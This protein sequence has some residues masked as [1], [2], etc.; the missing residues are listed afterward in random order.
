[1]KALFDHTPACHGDPK[2]FRIGELSDH[3]YFIPHTSRESA[4][5]KR[6]GS[7]YFQ[8]LCGDD[9]LFCYKPSLYDLEDFTQDDADTSEF[10]PITVPEVW[11]THGADRAQ[12]MT[13]PYPF[14]FDPPH[15]PEADPCGAY[16]KEFDGHIT[17]GKRYELC[18]E[19][20]D[21]CV[22]V[23]LN[24]SFVGYGETP[25]HTSSFDVTPYLHEGRNRLCAVVLKWCS[26]SY[27][28]D[29]DKLRLSGLFRDVYLL[30]RSEDGLRD[31][32]ITADMRGNVTLTAKASA[33]VTAEIYD[34]ET[35][36][37]HGAIETDGPTAVRVSQPTLWSAE[38]PYL[39]ELVLTCAGEVIRHPF[40]FRTV[41]VRGSG[42]IF[43][44]NGR[45][46]KL[47]GVNRHD[48]HPDLGYVVNE[49]N[50]ERE[51]LMMK[52]H[53]VNAIRTAHYPN[54]ARFYALCD[55]LGFYVLSEADMESHGCT[56]I[57]DWAY[58][59][60]D[61]DYADAIHDRMVRMLESLKNFTSI[62]I[63]S[64]GNESCWGENL[65][66]EAIYMKDFDP[67]RPIHYESA[68]AQYSK[69][70]PDEQAFIREHLDFF[71]QMYPSME[72][73]RSMY[74]EFPEVELPYLMCEYSHAM[75]N[76]SGDLRFYDEIIQSDPRY[77]GGFVWEWCD[78]AL[79]LTDERGVPYFGYGGD[80]GEYHHFGNICMDGLVTPDRR[81]HSA[82]LE[83]K[84]VY[85]PFRVAKEGNIL[86]VTNRHAF[87]D[88]SHYDISWSVTADGM[89]TANGAMDAN[90][91]P[92]ATVSVPCPV[93][94]P[95]AAADAVLTVR[96]TLA[97]PTLWAD[98]G[99]EV[100][101]FSFPLD[102]IPA[103]TPD[104]VLSPLMLTETRAAYIIQGTTAAG[105]D[106]TY[107]VRRD[108]GMLTE[109]T[110]TGVPLLRAPMYLNCFRAP[111]DND[112]SFMT[113]LNVANAWQ[114][115]RYFGNIEYPDT[116][117]RN[118]RADAA[119]NGVT[120][121][122]DLIFAAPGRKPISR[123]ILKYFIT[124]DGT[125]EIRQLASVSDEL[126]YFLPRYGYVFPWDARAESMRYLGY[127]PAECYEDKCS[128]AL[129][130]RYD[131]LPDDIK[132]ADTY[133]RPQECGSHC[134]TRWLT[135]TVAD[136]PLRLSCDRAFSFC[137]TNF[138]LHKV[139]KAAHR[140]DLSPM[141]S[142]DLYVDYRMSGVG[143]AS[144]GGQIPVESC[145]INAGDAIDFTVTLEIL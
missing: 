85:A 99:H 70:E 97:A 80:F 142:T 40:G 22:Y 123:G 41:D 55:R 138:D 63:W 60:N 126:P 121:T 89:L 35:L 2:Q 11:Q 17:P 86:T 92:G 1:M 82:L 109:M 81:P 83:M 101:A 18:F 136:T 33:P 115:N 73:V 43:T 59:A 72:K 46:V 38:N 114:S 65:K 110:V 24:G 7:P 50:I 37:W 12:Y 10:H 117:L 77:T 61:P 32:A 125:I 14:L 130:G 27:L 141:D 47:Y 6:E 5:G 95:I 122:G 76:S 94:E 56:Y 93:V 69:Y 8:S 31:F 116:A 45:P 107:T 134:G 13:S 84:A 4:A 120:I 67:T 16:I 15:V 29:Q 19:G 62:V 131:Y 3:A 88:L 103:A 96:I 30:E 135:L 143:S 66:R 25:H 39:Y 74:E 128:H 133:E 71:G 53:N 144:C 75:G 26:G 34:G 79:T 124:G 58:I 112:N 113:K 48:A 64:L 42:G 129:L 68:C 44:V 140:K 111:T 106:F 137:A 127:G 78:H 9:W 98:A 118:L 52:R 145:R 21:S 36:L 132:N 49:E 57:G 91:A 105:K 108:T 90:P 51:L 139:A 104:P 23:W 54:D 102:A 20:K 28:D 100:A 119:D 87:S